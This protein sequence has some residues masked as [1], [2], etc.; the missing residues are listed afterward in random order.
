MRLTGALTQDGYRVTVRD[1]GRG[2]P[3][4]EL[5]RV[6]EAFYMV[7][8]SRA[9]RQNGAGLGLALC[10]TIARLHGTAL[11]FKSEPGKGTEV[12]FLLPYGEEDAYE[13]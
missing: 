8:K 5:S 2:I 11:M 4:E 10:A 7:D 6:T 9:R 13:A 12:S 1:N 3:P